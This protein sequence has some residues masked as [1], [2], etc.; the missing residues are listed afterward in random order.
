MLG[1]ETVRPPVFRES[2]RWYIQFWA[3]AAARKPRGAAWRT[4][5]SRVGQ[6]SKAAEGISKNWN[7][8]EPF[9]LLEKADYL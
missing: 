2:T 8:M 1:A 9:Q 5:P 7:G 3:A 4:H 6:T